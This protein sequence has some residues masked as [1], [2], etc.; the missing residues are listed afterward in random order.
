MRHLAGRSP[1][2]KPGAATFDAFGHCCARR[3]DHKPRPVAHRPCCAR[4]MSQPVV[5]PS[6]VKCCDTGLAPTCDIAEKSAF[7]RPH[8]RAAAEDCHNPVLGCVA[9]IAVHPHAGQSSAGCPCTCY[10]R[11][12]TAGRPLLLNWSVPGGRAGRSMVKDSGR[13]RRRWL[14][15]SK[16]AAPVFRPGGLCIGYMS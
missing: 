16:K 2:S 9:R 4:P 7:L 14:V 13:R 6:C 5:T 11:H 15:V 8:L 10:S 3:L 1:P 12:M